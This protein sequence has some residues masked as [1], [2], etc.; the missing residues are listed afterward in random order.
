MVNPT[1]SK[2]WRFKYRIDG[3]KDG[4]AK[5]KEMLMTLGVYPDVALP[6]PVTRPADSLRW[7]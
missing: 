2:L 1:G 5:R 4:Q 3:V 7:T 6:K